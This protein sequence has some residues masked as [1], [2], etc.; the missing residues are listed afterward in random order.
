MT[1]T[2]GREWRSRLK[3]LGFTP[4]GTG[5]RKGTYGAREVGAFVQAVGVLVDEKYRAGRFNVQLNVNMALPASEPPHDVVILLAD[6][7]RSDVRIQEPWVHEPG[8]TTW[9]SR[10]EMEQS[11]TAFEVH[12]VPWLERY[13]Q[14][15]HLIAYFEGE[16]RR[17][18]GSHSDARTGSPMRRVLTR[19]GLVPR[20]APPAYQQYLL[21]LSMLYEELGETERAVELLNAYREWVE[22][23][24]MRSEIE[25]LARH[26]ALLTT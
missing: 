16:C 6:L 22:D 15:E 1:K 19:L 20:P 21:W 18:D 25:R 12:G 26:R 10:E 5:G 14:P 23:C 11:W 3:A 9:W 8:A 17:H 24:G 7:S 4:Q 2:I 13:G